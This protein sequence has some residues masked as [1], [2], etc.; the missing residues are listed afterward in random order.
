MR[1]VVAAAVVL[2]VALAVPASAYCENPDEVT[3]VNGDGF[4]NKCM[5]DVPARFGTVLAKNVATYIAPNQTAAIAFF[6]IC[7]LPF[8]FFSGAFAVPNIAP[9]TKARVG[10]QFRYMR[11]QLLNF[12]HRTNYSLCGTV[13][14]YT[15]FR[16]RRPCACAGQ[17]VGS[18]YGFPSG[19]STH[20][21]VVAA[22]LFDAAPGHPIWSR[23]FGLAVM[24]L[25]GAERISLGWHSLG[26]V[27]TG[28]TVGVASHFY[29]TRAPQ[30]MVFVDGAFMVLIGLITVNVDPDL[31]TY[32]DWDDMNIRAWFTQGLGF[33]LFC[34]ML[35]A[36]HYWL[37]YPDS[38]QRWAAL[39]ASLWAAPHNPIVSAAP[40]VNA[41]GASDSL[42]MGEVH[43]DQ[44]QA[45]KA[46]AV[47]AAVDTPTG[48]ERTDVLDGADW[49]FT[50]LAA[51]FC[52]VLTLIGYVV[53]QYS[54]YA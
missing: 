2:C 5:M 47:A 6:M 19:D 54:T 26:Q 34:Q 33:M 40:S 17:Q 39:K 22:L 4:F 12:L 16:Q 18:I 49:S 46:V 31:R 13:M 24:G 29:S 38:A 15:W 3:N 23:V 7:L 52:F 48:G 45:D 21:G 14:L 32:Q 9:A 37:T 35:L 20:A 53:E 28:L 41:S 36:R 42:L 10:A 25:V 8:W 44:K 43:S 51:F 27:L 11:L 1:A 50:L 30:F